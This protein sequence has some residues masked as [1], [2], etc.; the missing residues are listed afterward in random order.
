MKPAQLYLPGLFLLLLGIGNI[1]IGTYKGAEYREVVRTL[2]APETSAHL[3][4]ASPLRRFKVA[5]LSANRLYQRRK[6]AAGRIAFYNLVS[7]G[8][9]IFVLL[10]LPLLLG[11][12]FLLLQSR[13]KPSAQAT[14]Q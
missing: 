3:K 10:S 14:G 8:G 13:P 2:S 11:G 5:K 4:H 6:T 1:S 12:L 7:S 9:K